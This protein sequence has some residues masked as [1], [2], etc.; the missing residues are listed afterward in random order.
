MKINLT[1]MKNTVNF[2]II[3]LVFTFYA[4]KKDISNENKKKEIKN[5]A[6]PKIK[7]DKDTSYKKNIKLYEN[8]Y[9]LMPENLVNIPESNTILTYKGVEYE[10]D[11]EFE[12]KDQLLRSVILNQNNIVNHDENFENIIDL[13][14]EKY[15]TPKIENIKETNEEYEIYVNNVIRIT[16]NKY[17]SSIHKNLSNSEFKDI[18][19]F[20]IAMQGELISEKFRIVKGN[21][22]ENNDFFK[23]MKDITQDKIL[24][25]KVDVSIK[26]YSYKQIDYLKTY[27]WIDNEKLIILKYMYKN[28]YVGNLNKKNQK[29]T[30][31]INY[32]NYK[33]LEKNEIKL[34][35]EL[36]EESKKLKEK[37]TLKSI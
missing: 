19:S 36:D 2:L 1:I 3:L 14:I 7:I 4:C 28:D 12:F 31:T 5:S 10:F 27:T 18:G 25:L 20:G 13:Y 24:K 16:D 11:V 8:F 33:E 35:N 6:A 17:D 15:G 21:S 9:Y 37:Q 30:M 29:K 34:S 26:N 22:F 23:I 32:L